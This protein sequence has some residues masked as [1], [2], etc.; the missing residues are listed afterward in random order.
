[1][2]CPELAGGLIAVGVDGSPASVAALRWAADLARSRDAEIVVVRAWHVALASLAPYAPV[3]RR[4]AQEGERRRAEADLEG[5]MLTA[6]GPVPD[7]KVT[8][9]LV[10]GPPARVLLNQCADADLLVLG[11]HHADSPLRPTVGAIAAACLR[12]APCPVVIVTVAAASSGRVVAPGR[13]AV[14]AGRA[15]ATSG[16]TSPAIAAHAAAGYRADDR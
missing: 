12:Q 15:R 2:P 6:L 4:P 14:Y 16:E 5:V 11:G 10:C 9:A 3:S 13:G 8:A 1:M 7:V